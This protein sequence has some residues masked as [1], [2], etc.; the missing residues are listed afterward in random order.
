MISREEMLAIELQHA[1]EV[2]VKLMLEIAELRK[3]HNATLL[4]YQ[5]IEGKFVSEREAKLVRENANAIK[6]AERA[7]WEK[8]K[9]IC[10][11]RHTQLLA[12]VPHMVDIRTEVHRIGEA[13][14]AKS[15]QSDGGNREE[16]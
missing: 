11:D 3:Q 14:R 7:T 1:T 9:Q 5:E 8:A 15:L 6:D 13:I 12:E 2:K 4:R 16:T 10:D